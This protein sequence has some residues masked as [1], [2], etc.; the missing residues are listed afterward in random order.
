MSCTKHSPFKRCKP[1]LTG[2]SYTRQEDWWKQSEVRPGDTW[3]SSVKVSKGG[4][5]RSYTFLRKAKVWSIVPLP[6]D[7][8]DLTEAEFNELVEQ[9]RRETRFHSSLSKKFTHSAYVTIMAG[10][11]SA[12]SLILK[13][14]ERTPDHWFYALRYIVRKDIAAGRETFEDARTAWLDWGRENNYI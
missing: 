1:A 3:R 4:S 13:E 10:G 11:K 7:P 2:E 6:S 8:Q 5:Y 14:L 12:L 9:W